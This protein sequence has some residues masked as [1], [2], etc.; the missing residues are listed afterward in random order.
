VPK[1]PLA[2]RPDRTTTIL[3]VAIVA[4][5]STVFESLFLHRGLNPMDEGW[6]L[7]AA[8]QLHAGGTLYR[9]VFWVF[10][11]GHVLAAWIAYALDPPGLVLARAFYGAFTVALCVSLYFLGRRITTPG[12]ALLGA[13]LAAVAAPASHSSHLIFGYRYLVWSALALWFFSERL[14]TGNPRWMAAAGAATG[15]ALVFRIDPPAAVTA[16]IGLAVLTQRPGW[17]LLW[18]DAASFALGFAVVVGPVLLWL[19]LSVGPQTLWLE[20][21]VRP[22]EMHRRQGKPFPP[23]ELPRNLGLWAIRL[24]FVSLQF[25]LWL[26]V[27]LAYAVW[28]GAQLLR[29][30]RGGRPFEQPLLLAIVVWGGMFFSRSLIGRSDEPHL[31]SAVPP[32]LLLAGHAVG[33]GAARLRSRAARG[34]LGAAV[35]ALWVC[36]TAVPLYPGSMKRGAV[37]VE[38][39]GGDTLFHYYGNLWANFDEVVRAIQER[40]RPGDVVLDLTASPLFHVAAERGGPGRADLVMPGTFLSEAEELALIERLERAR[41]ALVVTSRRPFDEKIERSPAGHAP[42]LW[43]WV[44]RHYEPAV[45]LGRFALLAPRDRS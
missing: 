29:S 14:R 37:P 24:S 44:G 18:R 35:F 8:M 12:F 3:H 20:V 23:L 21:V 38:T 31:D 34:A 33:L 39:L 27:Y 7:Y 32:V 40:T 11:P 4:A 17:R 26:A 42:R 5:L 22:M 6:P 15:M 10:P 25:R 9:E 45:T 43:I 16:G 13:C 41:P 28:L 30:L 19:L 2:E 36:V 1:E